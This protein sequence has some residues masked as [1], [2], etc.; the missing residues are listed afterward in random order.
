MV[1]QHMLVNILALVAILLITGYYATQGLFSAALS[2]VTAVFASL[3]AMGL[4]EP[5][6]G[7]IGSYKPAHA[8]GVTF[9]LLFL[10]ALSL[11]RL[12]AD[13][14]IPKA[15]RLNK[16]VDSVGGG[17]AGFFAAMVI[18]GTSII[19]FE[20]LP[21]RTAIFGEKL[22]FDRY[23]GGMVA[24]EPGV[25]AAPANIWLMPDR[26]TLAIWHGASGRSLGG[27]ADRS[28]SDIHPDLTV[29]SYGY[30]NTVEYAASSVL[31]ADLLTV[32]AAYTTDAQD[33]LTRLKIP[34]DNSKQ[35]VVLR[36][37]VDRGT[38][39]PKVSADA[40]SHFRITASNIRLLT[41]KEQQYY[42]IGHLVN[43]IT[44]EETPLDKGHLVDDYQNG[45]V[46]QDWV[47]QI[48]RD[49]KPRYLE[50]KQLARVDLTGKISDK[51]APAAA[52]AAYPKRPYKFNQAEL[53]ITIAGPNGSGIPDARV[54]LMPTSVKVRTVRAEV[55]DSYGNLRDAV[56]AINEGNNTWAN[57][58]GKAGVPGEGDFKAQMAQARDRVT[59]KGMDEDVGWAEVVAPIMFG[60]CAPDGAQN[61]ASL[62]RAFEKK[63]IPLLGTDIRA[64]GK[65]GPDGKVTL[66]G[67]APGSYQL[68]CSGG[69]TDSYGCWVESIT[70]KAKEEASLKLS[71]NRALLSIVLKP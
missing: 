10:F 27:S 23:A 13:Y 60:S 70:L 54:Y 3:L 48:G 4:F 57:A 46:V 26:F 14:L 25:A 66:K 5:L 18:V 62:P 36:I 45:K 65:T 32:D 28:F 11:C 20:M 50:V 58:Q 8:R 24:S 16:T 44:F 56:T 39:Q 47:F 2:L 40:D 55:N 63:I 15:I 33:V 51:P 52:L 41:D 68:I 21:I 31:P 43:G 38:E 30:R 61:V 17:L 7:I 37:V 69:S 1:E 64:Q 59:S 71:V 34:A 42:P 22:G 29:E 12:A 35:A 9:L 19:G 67:V 49:E 6:S 53:D